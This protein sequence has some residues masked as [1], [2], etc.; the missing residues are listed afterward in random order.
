MGSSRR[1]SA[2][3]ECNCFRAWARW[4][5]R[6]LISSP[7]SAM[8]QLYCGSQKTGSY[9]NPP[10]PWG[11]QVDKAL[12]GR[13]GPPP[14][15]R[16]ER[17]PPCSRQTGPGAPPR[18]R[19]PSHPAVSGNYPH[20]WAGPAPVRSAGVPGRKHPGPAPQSLHLQARVVRQGRAAR[21]RRP[22]PGPSWPHW[23]QRCHRLRPLPGNPENPPGSLSVI[24]RSAS[25]APEFPDFPGITGGDH[26]GRGIHGLTPPPGPG[27][28]SSRPARAGSSISST[29]AGGKEPFSPVACTST[30]SPRPVTTKLASTSARES[31]W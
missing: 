7:T 10:S 23:P 30:S 20:P 8:V 26:Q 16:R 4:L 1:I 6:F 18:G 24:P 3:V 22:P 17:P 25:K 29:R 19:L 5:I 31:S 14:S 13:P 27:A 2:R 9:P 12:A 11:V 15:A 28:V 21:C